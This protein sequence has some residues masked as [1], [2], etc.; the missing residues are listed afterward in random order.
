MAQSTG[1]IQGSVHDAS[2]ASIAHAQIKVT[3]TETGLSRQSESDA[4][5]TYVVPSLPPGHYL[6]TVD[7]AS[8][9]EARAENVVVSVDRDVPLNFLMKVASANT[10][11]EVNAAE[12]TALDLTSPTQSQTLN[13][14]VVQE[15]PLNGRHFIDLFPLVA[16]TVT[17]PQN[18]SLSAPT[19]GTG[20][21]GFNSAG[22]RE[23]MT[24]LMINGISHTDLQQNQI[25]FQPTINIVNEFRCR[26]LFR[27]PST[28]V[29]AESSST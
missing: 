3:S 29:R 22:Y 26:T 11:V 18:G 15:V 7:A 2:G 5:G 19:R 4:A 25:A 14:Q 10:A 21:S 1:S 23:D 20:A 8:M 27:V 28:A 12:Q 24:N 16:G 13:P 9:T 17:A 6:V